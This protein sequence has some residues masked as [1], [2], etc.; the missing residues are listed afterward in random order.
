MRDLTIGQVF[1]LYDGMIDYVVLT[2]P[3]GNGD[4]DGNSKTRMGPVREHVDADQPGAMNTALGSYIP[5]VQRI[6]A[7]QVPD[8]IRDLLG[9]RDIHDIIDQPKGERDG[10]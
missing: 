10:E 3:F 2:S 1:V 7:D 4:D 6:T 9:A 5:T 8:D